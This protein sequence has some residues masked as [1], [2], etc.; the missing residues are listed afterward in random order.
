MAPTNIDNEVTDIVSFGSHNTTGMDAAKIQWTK[1]LISDCDIDFF[2]I[3]EHFKNT[4]T[5]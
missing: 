1:D 4:K 2:A 3:Q 5:T